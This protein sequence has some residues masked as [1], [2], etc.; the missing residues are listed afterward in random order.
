MLIL[1]EQW[2]KDALFCAGQVTKPRAQY[3]PKSEPRDYYK[4][5]FFLKK[6]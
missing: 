3:D 4:L 1:L 6:S 5:D 2:N